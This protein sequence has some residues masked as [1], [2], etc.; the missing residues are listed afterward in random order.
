MPVPEERQKI[1]NQHV[2][3]SELDL[4]P[5]SVR[6]Y[7]VGNIF[8]RRFSYLV[9]YD[10][11]EFHLLRCGIDGLLK[12]YSNPPAYVKYE[13]ARDTIDGSTV[14]ELK[15]ESDDYFSRIDITAFDAAVMVQF[16][17]E[18]LQNYGTAFKLNPGWY[19]FDYLSKKVKVTLPSGGSATEVQIVVYYV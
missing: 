14:T 19:S 7:D 13:V 6:E 12:V 10:G 1:R 4:D 16:G 18:P 15:I 3:P 17:V 11:R 9:G 5:G 8:E 2:D